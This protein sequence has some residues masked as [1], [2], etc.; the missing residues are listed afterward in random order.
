MV[1]A[2][3][4]DR[5]P[6]LAYPASILMLVRLTDQLVYSS[7]VNE[8]GAGSTRLIPDVLARKQ[9]RR[10]AGGSKGTS[11]SGRNELPSRPP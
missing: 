3:L 5:R 4:G 6:R 1:H 7:H 9:P 8:I 11:A 2:C 10:F